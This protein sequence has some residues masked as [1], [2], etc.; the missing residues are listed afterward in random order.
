M[1]PS[2]GPH[3]AEATSQRRGEHASDRSGGRPFR[4]SLQVGQVSSSKEHV[5][6]ARR[7]EDSGFDL[8]VAGD[9]LTGCAGPMPSLGALAGATSRIRIGTMVSNNDF[10]HPA[11]LAR[12]AATLDVV[13]DGRLELGLGAGQGREEYERAGVAFEPIATRLGRLEESLV[14]LPGSSTGRSSPTRGSTT[15]C[16]STAASPARSRG[17]F[18]SSQAEEATGS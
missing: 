14:I 18:R 6:L 5:E 16:S 17:I 10:Q 2:A 1:A 11:L 4:F 3:E 7:A 15:A 8:V 12:D 13:S 9:H